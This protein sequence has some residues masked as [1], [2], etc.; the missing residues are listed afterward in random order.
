[1]TATLSAALL[2]VR[3]L[4]ALSVDSEVVSGVVQAGCEPGLMDLTSCHTRMGLPV[5]LYLTLWGMRPR[6]TRSPQSEVASDERP[7]HGIGSSNRV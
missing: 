6:S 2:S 7:W 5:S 1:M 3:P 4:L